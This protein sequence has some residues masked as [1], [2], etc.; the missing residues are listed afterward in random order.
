MG[1]RRP[2]LPTVSDDGAF[3]T[4]EM[5]PASSPHPHR[6][7]GGI[8]LWHQSSYTPSLAFVGTIFSWAHEVA[9]EQAGVSD[10][11]P[12]DLDQKG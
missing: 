3:G 8:S 4:T 10:S 11:T 1:R 7:N 2:R 6:L 12:R 9:S 5:V